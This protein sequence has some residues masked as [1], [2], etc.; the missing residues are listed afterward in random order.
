MT[1]QGLSLWKKILHMERLISL[2]KS[3]FAQPL[4]PCS[5]TDM[6][7]TPNLKRYKMSWMDQMVTWVAVS[8]IFTK[9]A[10]R[11]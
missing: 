5:D 8:E 2:A 1:E 7:G 6:E 9:V 11:S 4:K 10:Y 3:L